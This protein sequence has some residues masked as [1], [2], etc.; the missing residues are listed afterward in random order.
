LDYSIG[1]VIQASV[2][3]LSLSLDALTASFAYGCT[4]TKIPFK[5]VIVIK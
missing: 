3:S 2:L 4:G 5:S 1:A